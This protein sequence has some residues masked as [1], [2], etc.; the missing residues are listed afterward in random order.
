MSTSYTLLVI[1]LVE[2]CSHIILNFANNFQTQRNVK[3]NLM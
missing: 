1:Y 2:L 3:F